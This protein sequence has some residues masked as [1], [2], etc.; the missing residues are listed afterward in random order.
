MSHKKR[1]LPLLLALMMLIGLAPLA[2]AE[3]PAIT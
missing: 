2:Q 1:L 3:A